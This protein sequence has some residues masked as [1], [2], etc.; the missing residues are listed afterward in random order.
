MT[1]RKRPCLDEKT[2]IEESEKLR[3][4]VKSICEQEKQHLQAYTRQQ[5]FQGIICALEVIEVMQDIPDHSPSNKTMAI[6][7]LS[8]LLMI[9]PKYKKF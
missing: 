6:K 5:V 1:E 2:N 4:I 3:E 8:F 7:L 9:L